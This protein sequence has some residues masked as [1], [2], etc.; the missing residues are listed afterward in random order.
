MH[1]CL[2]ACMHIRMYAYAHVC[3]YACMHICMYAY[4]HVCIYAWMYVCMYAWTHVHR[5]TCMYVHI[6]AHMYVCMYSYACMYVCMYEHMQVC[7][8]ICMHVHMYWSFSIKQLQHAGPESWIC[9]FNSWW[10]TYEIFPSMYSMA[11]IC[12]LAYIEQRKKLYHSIGKAVDLLLAIYML[13]QEVADRYVIPLRIHIW[14][15][16]Y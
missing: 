3:I 14:V 8:Y 2:Y 5:Y 11:V 13:V 15:T 6:Y 7:I 4:M 10:R 9:V 12:N 16:M 1:V